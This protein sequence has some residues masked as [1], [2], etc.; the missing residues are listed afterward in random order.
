MKK[1]VHYKFKKKKSKAQ[2]EGNKRYDLMRRHEK[3]S[4]IQISGIFKC[5][6]AKT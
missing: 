2:N 6:D 1:G 5:K 3:V 4:K